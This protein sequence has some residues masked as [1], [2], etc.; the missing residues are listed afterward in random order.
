MSY[1][2]KELSEYFDVSKTTVR[3][4]WTGEFAE[5]LSEGARPPKGKERNYSEED[6]L[7]LQTISVGRAQGLEYSEIKELLNSG[8]RLE[9]NEPPKPSNPP[10]NEDT[11]MTAISAYVSTLELYETRL[12]RTAV[13]LR[14]E[15]EARLAAEIRATKAETELELL[16]DIASK[17]KM[18]FAEWLRS[19][20][21]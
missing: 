1:T 7:V 19:R 17:P 6:F 8:Q 13:E 12:E 16:K 14:E 5:W 15:R 21:S 4:V 9:S 18:S 2:V 11:N 20:R 10:H 3:S